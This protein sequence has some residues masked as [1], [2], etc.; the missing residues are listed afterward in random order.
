MLVGQEEL[1][2][3]VARKTLRERSVPPI[4]EHASSICDVLLLQPILGA[5][6]ST[7]PDSCFG[8]KR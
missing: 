5:S 2:A 4:R 3:P 7:Q 6:S 8:T 1:R